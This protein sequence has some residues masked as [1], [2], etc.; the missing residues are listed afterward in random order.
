MIRRMV[1]LGAG[2]LVLTFGVAVTSGKRRRRAAMADEAA[3]LGLEYAGAAPVPPAAGLEAFPLLA[4]SRL[5]FRRVT[6][7]VRWREPDRLLLAFDLQSHPGHRRRAFTVVAIHVPGRRI[8]RFQARPLATARASATLS[9]SG[10]HLVDGGGTLEPYIVRAPDLETAAEIVDSPLM[11]LLQTR[12]P[13]VAIE[14]GGE[15]V[16]VYRPRIDPA[17]LESLLAIAR[18]ARAQIGEAVRA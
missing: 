10:T 12:V 17:H 18:D 9:G 8:P 15:W 14:A 6:N 2:G 13:P 16:L 7:L 1:A 3:R 4:P 11:R 5:R